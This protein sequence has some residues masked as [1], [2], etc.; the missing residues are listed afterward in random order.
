MA[1]KSVFQER[2]DARLRHRFDERLM[3]EM[4][5]DSYE[6]LVE[7]LLNPAVS[8]GTI[9]AALTEMGITAP[10]SNLR[11]WRLKCLSSV[12]K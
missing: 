12:K 7:A 8:V 3:L 2:L 6:D 10:K 5:A 4:D 9:S 11:R 1:K